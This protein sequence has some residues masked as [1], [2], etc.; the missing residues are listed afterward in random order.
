MRPLRLDFRRP[1]R[2]GGSAP[3]LVLLLGM[4]VAVFVA[5]RYMELT[6]AVAGR[7]R[8]VGQLQRQL[9]HVASARHARADQ[10]ADGRATAAD[11]KQAA[12]VSERLSLPWDGLL[13]GIERAATQRDQDVALLAI[14]PD[15]HRRVVKITG[16]ARDFPAMVAYVNLLAQ[17]ASMDDVYIESHQIQQQDTQ[18]PVRFELAAHWRVAP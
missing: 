2:N 1:P 16:E 6:A 7:E 11:I 14:R 17:D 12:V 5:G 10:E 4:A 18:R 9:G 15:A 3:V 13:R 8:D